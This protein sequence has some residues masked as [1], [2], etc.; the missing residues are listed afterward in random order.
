MAGNADDPSLAALGLPK[1]T[2]TATAKG[3]DAPVAVAAV[4]YLVTLDD[5]TGCGLTADII[6]L[7]REATVDST[8]DPPGA[9]VPA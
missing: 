3:V 4:W 6:L 1:F 5:R 2:I 9:G 8:F 7:P